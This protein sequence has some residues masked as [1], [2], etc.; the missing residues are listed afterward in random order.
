MD[1]NFL[2]INRSKIASLKKDMKRWDSFEAPIGS[3]FTALCKTKGTLDKMIN[4]W[5]EEASDEQEID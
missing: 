4:T 5:I 3:A 2:K 1:F